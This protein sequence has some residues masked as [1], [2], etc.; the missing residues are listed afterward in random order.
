[1]PGKFFRLLLCLLVLAGPALA[2]AAPPDL[3]QD[4]PC[5]MAQ[6]G[7]A[8]CC[9]AAPASD[10]PACEV[11]P[12]P[13]PQPQA[14]LPTPS[15]SL[16]TPV[17]GVGHSCPAPPRILDLEQGYALPAWRPPQPIYLRLSSLLI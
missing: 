4:Q 10:C 6:A 13:G 16:E 12:A 17:A 2:G 3:G 9:C 5:S 15:S 11:Q 7:M 1:L 8:C 14:W